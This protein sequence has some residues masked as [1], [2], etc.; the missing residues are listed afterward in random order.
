MGK[1]DIDTS[2]VVKLNDNNYEHWKF[3][4]T[5]V[6]QSHDL[7]EIVTGDV[8]AP[9]AAADGTPPDA[10]ALKEW[11]KKDVKAKTI[12]GTTLTAAQ[13]NHIYKCKTSK[14]IFDELK[15][16]NSDS[17]TLNKQHTMTRFFSYKNDADS[18]LTAFR[19]IEQ[20]AQSL[21][22]MNVKL[23]SSMIVSKIVSSLSDEKHGAF[24]KAWDSVSPEHQTLSNLHARLKKEEL[25]MKQKAPK[26]ASN[27][28]AF[29]AHPQQKHGKGRNFNRNGNKWNGNDNHGNNNGNGKFNSNGNGNNYS[30]GNGNNY[31]NN[32]R[33]PLGKQRASNSNNVE[34]NEVT[35]TAFVASAYQQCNTWISDSGA[36]QHITGRD[37]WFISFTPFD[38]PKNISML[39]NSTTAKGM[40]IVQL[41]ASINGEWQVITIHNVLYVP[42]AVNLFSE[43]QL[44]QKGYTIMRDR[45]T[46]VFYD[47]NNSPILTA[48]MKN[49][50][51]IMRFRPLQQHALACTSKLWHSRL[52][53]VNIE[54]IKNTIKQNAATG[55][56][57]DELSK[58]FTSAKIR[59]LAKKKAIPG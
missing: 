38:H 24:K 1:G 40:G 15:T 32:G 20:L 2:H 23:D 51:Y 27:S 13:T 45:S 59:H 21:L 33:K 7:W 50:V 36:S 41:E 39:N 42:R 58:A 9:V 44:A 28:T 54:Y 34:S 18:P 17:S 16:L 6:L 31:S 4:V 57:L 14:E 55:I 26:E 5:L 46:A 53:H 19:E 52:A 48:D 3:Q 56:K 47:N 43:G 30:N 22:N 37:D 29:L 25:E 8:T 10:D 12:I 49:N 11:N 35:T